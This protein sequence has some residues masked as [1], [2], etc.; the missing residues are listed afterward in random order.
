MVM[1]MGGQVF[2]RRRIA[3]SGEVDIAATGA[4]R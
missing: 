4:P 2:E 1:A 3:G